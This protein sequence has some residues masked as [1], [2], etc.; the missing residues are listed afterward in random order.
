MIKSS[1]TCLLRAHSAIDIMLIMCFVDSAK[2]WVS[3]GMLSHPIGKV[4]D[5][6]MIFS[7]FSNV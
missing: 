7:G 5:E 2:Q 4:I 1:F 6:G 3:L